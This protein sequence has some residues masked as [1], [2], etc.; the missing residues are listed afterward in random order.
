V[1]ANCNFWKQIIDKVLGDTYCIQELFN[2]KASEILYHM[3]GIWNWDKYKTMVD[4]PFNI[5]ITTNSGHLLDR[6]LY[7]TVKGL[8]VAARIVSPGGSII[9]AAACEDGLPD[10]GCFSSILAE[11]REPLE[12]IETLTR[13]ESALPDQWQVQILAGVLADPDVFIYSDGLSDEQMS[14]A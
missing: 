9:M 1:E 12:A 4:A 13:S 11:F 5:V 10:N 8:S 3:Y 14:R 2:H 6:N 7:K